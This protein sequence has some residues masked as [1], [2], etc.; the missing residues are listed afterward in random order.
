MGEGLGS[1]CVTNAWIPDGYQDIPYDRK[2]PRRRLRA[3]LDEI[4]AEPL[5]K[6]HVLDGVSSIEHEDSLRSRNEGFE[7]AVAYLKGVILRQ[8]IGQACWF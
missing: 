7:K 2:G 3:S 5:D 4:F 8:P 1:P 6:R